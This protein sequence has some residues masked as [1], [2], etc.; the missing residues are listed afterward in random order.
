MSRQDEMR[1]LVQG[2]RAA[3]VVG[4]GVAIYASSNSS[5][6]WT[7]LIKHGIRRV[8]DL[9]PTKSDDWADAVNRTLQVGL[10]MSDTNML[11]SS[12]GMVQDGLNSLGDGCF[13][14]WLK[15][16]FSTLSVSD[17][18]QI[19]A[20]GACGLPILTTNYDDL[21]EKQLR[22]RGVTWR[23]TRELQEIGAGRAEEVA[24]LHGIWHRADTVIFG[25]QSYGTLLERQ[26]VQMLQRA[27]GA[28]KSLIFVGCGDGT[29]DP[30]IGGL[31]GSLK[32][33]VPDSSVTHFFLHRE[34]QEPSGLPTNVRLISYGDNYVDLA[35]FLE[36]LAAPPEDVSGKALTAVEV[37]LT[38]SA[39]GIVA[40]QAR[41]EVLLAELVDDVE[42]AN[43]S[44]LLMPPVLLPVTQQAYANSQEMGVDERISR[45]NLADETRTGRRILLAAE[46]H[47]GLTTAL[48]WLIHEVREQG[49]LVAPVYVDF[50]TLNAGKNP[51]RKRVIQQLRQ[52]G[53]QIPDNGDI[54]DIAL[55]LDNVVQDLKGR[56]LDR[57]IAELGENHIAYLV[58]GTRQGAEHELMKSLSPALNG[59]TQRYVGRMNSADIL[60]LANKVAPARARELTDRAVR[61]LGQ[62]HLPRTPYTICM[63]LIALMRGHTFSAI[64][65][66]TA[67]LDAYITLMLGAADP[68]QDSRLSLDYLDRRLLLGVLAGEFVR[69]D[70][71]ALAHGEVAKL[72][73][74]FF[75]SV[76][77]NEDSLDALNDLI[78]RRILKNSN[79]QVGFAHSSYVHLFAAVRARDD[80]DLRNLVFN[81][82][83]HYAE[84][85]RHYAGLTRD[86]VE[87]LRKVSDILISA[88]SAAGP[89]ESGHF[90]GN[91]PEA[92]KVL[93]ASTVEE[94]LNSLDLGDAL[95]HSLSRARSDAQ[96]DPLDTISDDERE[97][98]PADR[99]EDAPPLYQ[100]MTALSLVS[101]VLRDSESVTDLGLKR[102]VLARTLSVWGK[103]VTL[104]ETD[105]EFQEFVSSLA[106]STAAEAGATGERL[107]KFVMGMERSA[108]VLVGVTAI[109][110]SLAS[111]KL[112]RTLSWL[113]D[114]DDFLSDA[115][116]SILGAILSLD[117]GDGWAAQFL[118]VHEHHQ[119]R[120]AI[121]AVMVPF[122][123]AAYYVQPL[124]PDDQRDVEEFVAV[125]KLAQVST[126]NNVQRKMF[127]NQV[128][129][130]LRKNRNLH[131]QQ[132]LGAG[133]TVM[134]KVDNADVDTTIHGS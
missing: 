22:R 36:S 48:R 127:L 94:L 57:V 117:L 2:G 82:A 37:E 132:R 46:E 74:D 25:G 125:R 19:D 43:L 53:Y 27:V 28:T 122:A 47:S 75:D 124:S 100:I 108:P 96:F 34:G 120:R 103:V 129:E 83:L 123:T 104:L 66:E 58:I 42:N 3:F 65:S 106:R 31:L 97:P 61:I 18:R 39:A 72:F 114:D 112:A 110:S 109:N 67:L 128:K 5:L 51:L 10:D 32:D 24:H 21:I 8:V 107:E 50:R 60:T 131:A 101:T 102:E 84:I 78:H 121:D 93:D 64:S 33:L 70:T 9:D 16:E 134:R 89:A 40:D 80:Q 55:A 59:V 79:G 7:E 99:I 115:G 85:V 11:I 71:A 23:D 20:L 4:A 44:D 76:D 12:A 90:F 49:Q 95:A 68:H 62:E 52:A 126:T 92:D 63:L 14:D 35:P 77:W 87:A 1:S 105:P 111:R 118:K 41:S 26:G 88:S 6:T 119:L 86:D 91:R 29:T 54:P 130:A 15:A 73:D 45:C 113:F 116:A 81:S 69:R 17:G 38:H 56:T 133:E 30:N 13:A 98:F